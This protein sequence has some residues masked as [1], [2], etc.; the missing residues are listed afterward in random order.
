[1]A[2]SAEHADRFWNAY[3]VAKAAEQLE[4]DAVAHTVRLRDAVEARG[5][6]SVDDINTLAFASA[7]KAVGIERNRAAIA[8]YLRECE[9]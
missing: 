9:L 1:M 6:G 8:N 5:I 2:F 4:V 3:V 7:C